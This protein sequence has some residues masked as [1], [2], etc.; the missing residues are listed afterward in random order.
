MFFDEL[1]GLKRLV[2]LNVFYEQP[3][4]FSLFWPGTLHARPRIKFGAGSCAGIHDLNP[5]A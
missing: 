1:N 2:F 3:R 4:V 5:N